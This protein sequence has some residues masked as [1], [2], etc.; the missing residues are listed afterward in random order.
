MAADLHAHTTASDGSLPPAGLIER[1][2]QIGLSA[3]AVTDHD[4]VEGLGEA[5][6]AAVR[7]GVRLVPGVELNTDATGREIHILGF[8]VDWEG[9]PL[10]D[11][12][13]R[14]R[15]A[16]RERLDRIVRSLCETG[17]RLEH[18][19]VLEIVGGGSAGRIH[20]ARALVEAGEAVS[21]NEAFER[22]LVPGRPG[23]VRRTK[24]QPA[25]AVRLIRAAGGVAVLAHPGLVGDADETLVA[26]LREAG[27]EGLE[28]YYPAHDPQEVERY[29]EWADKFDLVATGGSDFHGI[30]ERWGD[31]GTV[32]VNDEV[33]DALAERAGRRA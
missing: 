22:Y 14:L 8:Y 19:R 17:V 31:L 5:R 11:R 13:S 4:T 28:V 6:E 32:W 15:A 27:L 21:V 23:Y 26:G 16:R 9:G 12:L 3:V 2:R 7:L 30:D 29:R 18:D 10:L 20:V 25:E 24:L 1:A 33:V